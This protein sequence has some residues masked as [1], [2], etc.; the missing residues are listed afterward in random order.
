VSVE[1]EVERASLAKGTRSDVMDCAQ[2]FSDVCTAM[3]DAK[4]EVLAFN[5]WG[6]DTWSGRTADEVR[7][8]MVDIPEVLGK[9]GTANDEVAQAL[10]WFADR[11]AEYQDRHEFLQS[12][13]AA[14]SD[15]VTDA[16]LRRSAAVERVRS[17]PAALDALILGL[18][19]VSSD[20]EVASLDRQLGDLRGR[21]TDL[22]SQFDINDEEFE[23]WVAGAIELIRNADSVLYN[24]G[25]DQFWNQTMSPILDVVR[26][27]VEVLAIIVTIVVMLTGVG[28]LFALALGLMLLTLSAVDI[29]GTAASGREVSTDQWLSLGLDMAAVATLG[30]TSWAGGAKLASKASKAK[31]AKALKPTKTVA[32][33]IEGIGRMKHVDDARAATVAKFELFEGV[34]NVGAGSYMLAQ[35]DVAGG[36]GTMVGGAAGFG[37]G[38]GVSAGLR[39]IAGVA[40]PAVGAVGDLFGGAEPIASP[41]DWPG[42]DADALDADPPTTAPEVDPT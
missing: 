1:L 24:S 15:E 12:Q 38:K 10:R 33:K 39:G 7:D 25:W 3:M 37:S 18:F 26:S 2:I 42:L 8:G 5:R 6:G 36:I 31:A 40:G 11:L 17:D 34:A 28:T 9:F 29:I 14:S 41:K 22:R 27:V 30:M 32:P 35:G 4:T 16:L 20:P 23:G 21:R 19:D 13:N